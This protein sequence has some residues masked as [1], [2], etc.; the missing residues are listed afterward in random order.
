MTTFTSLQALQKLNRLSPEDILYVYTG[1]EGCRCGCNGIYRYSSSLKDQGKR[2]RGYDFDP[3]DINDR[4][5]R[6]SLK[7]AQMIG[8]SFDSFVEMD[9]GLRNEAYINISRSGSDKVITLY[10]QP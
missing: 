9:Q 10:F 5:I 6:S 4:H 1:R 8:N 2:L 3:K 7:S